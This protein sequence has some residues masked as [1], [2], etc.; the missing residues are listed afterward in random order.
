[1]AVYIITVILLIKINYIK[2]DF[3]FTPWGLWSGISWDTT[4]CDLVQEECCIL[5]SPACWWGYSSILT[6][7]TM[8]S[9][10]TLVNF[11]QTTRRHVSDDG[12]LQSLSVPTRTLLVVLTNETAHKHCWIDSISLIGSTS[13]LRKLRRWTNRGEG[14]PAPLLSS[15]SSSVHPPICFMSKTAYCICICLNLSWGRVLKILWII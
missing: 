12:T 6:M 11:Y 10:E 13:S 4:P 14:T 3:R 7:A 8:H 2:L 1:M 15:T 5:F 9:S